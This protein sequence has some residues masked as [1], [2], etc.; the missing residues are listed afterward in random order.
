MSLFSD[1]SPLLR[2][3]AIVIA[4]LSLSI[5]WGIRGDY[6]HEFGAMMPGMLC[7][8]AV[9]LLSGRADWRQRVLFFAFFGALGWG[10]GGS[11]SYMPTMSYTHSGHWPTQ[12]YGWVAVF[13]VGFLWAG[14]GGAGTAYPAVETRERLTALFRPL[15]FV[16]AAWAVEYIIHANRSD[17][18]QR[19]P[20]YWLDSEWMEA[21]WTLLGLCAWEL[22]DRRLR[23]IHWLA[24]YGAAGAAVGWVVQAAL[25]AAGLAQPLVSLLVRP[26]GDLSALNPATGQPLDPNNLV[27]NWP[28][29]LLDLGPHF[30]GLVAL[31]LG[32][33][34]FFA[35]YGKWR[36]GSSLILH[37][38]AG[39]YI[40]FLIGP[41]FLTSF[42]GSVGG[43]RMT[44]PRGDSWA[45]IVGCF[46]GMLVYMYRNGLKPVGYTAIVSGVI[47]GLGF[48][49]AQFAKILLTIPG[50]PIFSSDPVWLREWQHWRSANWHNL[51][52]E[53]GVGLLYGLAIAVSMAL[54]ADRL[55]PAVPEPRVR[56][57]TESFSVFFLLI[58]LLYVN[59]VKNVPDWTRVYGAHAALPAMMKAPL[60]PKIELS[61]LAWF[62]VTFL[63]MGVALAAILWAHQRRPLA[64]VPPGW[65]GRGQL[66]YLIFLWAILIGNWEKALPG[67]QEQRLATEWLMMVNGL[68]ATFLL[69]NFARE[70]DIA[71]APSRTDFRPVVRKAVITAVAG[72]LVAMF[73]F[74][75]MHH[76]LY[77]GKFDGFGGRN[78]RFGPEAD[79]RIRPILKDKAHR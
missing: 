46:A 79:W 76:A 41:V 59:L 43:F 40:V 8:I 60:F 3:P 48:M 23:Q 39:S 57:W 75:A 29:F 12:V 26:Q 67:F 35:R 5:G 53:Q 74:T 61:A 15:A 31:L 14:M 47:G 65:V 22:W 45:N 78:L 21:N 32:L 50:N 52:V 16:M 17:F 68:I 28:Q 73:G 36:S 66:L 44:P 25:Q 55:K 38:T 56:K 11:I 34:I 51:V 49:F 58:V 1:R 10:F 9:C 33:A 4:M 18:R 30:G 27:T 37:I 72:I 54:L 77:H 2:W 62:N 69:L 24:I 13:V 63:L 64:I 71:P 6:G 19:D 70:E 20:L 42:F 7:A